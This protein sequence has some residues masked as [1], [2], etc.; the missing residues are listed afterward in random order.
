MNHKIIVGL[1]ALLLVS[2]A[3]VSFVDFSVGTASAATSG[4]FTYQLINGGT[5]VEITGYN[6]SS[7]NVVIPSTI[8][9][10]PVVSIGD[11]AFYGFYKMSTVTIPNSVTYIGNYSFYNC[12][13]SHY[14]D[15]NNI[16]IPD[17]VTRIGDY[18]FAKCGY[19]TTLT[20][21]NSVTS[22]G[23][24]AFW[25]CGDLTSVTIPNSVISIGQ[26]AFRE[27]GIG[28][29]SI[30]SGL[31]N[32]GLYAFLDCRGLYQITVDPNN[33]KYASA[34]GTL[35]D[36][37]MTT[38]IQ[39]PQGNS[40]GNAF[41][42]PDTVTTIGPNAFSGAAIASVTISNKVTSI[43]NSTFYG[44]LGLSTATIGSGVTSIGNNAFSH[45]SF[46]TS[47]SFLGLV[48]PVNV[49]T[50]W[51]DSTP[52]SI[53][54]HAFAASNFPAPGN[55]WNGLTMG[56]TLSATPPGAPTGLVAVGALQHITL[57]WT[58]PSVGVASNYL[59]YRGTA[60]G[61]E[62]STPIATVSSWTTYQDD[63]VIVG[64]PYFY[65]VK[66]NNSYGAS[67]FSNEATATTTTTVTVPSA[68]QNFVATSG[69]NKDT[70]TWSAPAN[71]GGSAITGYKIYRSSG[72]GSA[73]QIGTTG[74]N[75]LT[76]QD[77]QVTAGTTY[78]YYVVAMNSA[79]SGTQSASKSA[80][81]ESS[82]SGGTS[83]NNS[84]YTGIAIV[85]IVLILIGAFW[86]MRS[87]KKSPPKSP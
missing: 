45:C 70:L 26:E 14:T 4:G 46:L 79:G 61:S 62:S 58:A 36:K 57:N 31:T 81:P 23:Y 72:G 66:A 75:T 68:P 11:S 64:T 67:P 20:I 87:R 77:T 22:I 65:K 34:G 15:L 41:I 63:N 30:G 83:N 19:L 78:S 73:S 56:A 71:N 39:C 48:V 3:V 12:G 29:V 33:Q 51:I 55:V 47:I 42:F 24:R 43:G 59:V 86:Y 2:T 60:A 49:G 44:L 69:V 27:S 8:A 82:S 13:N 54:G 6:Q 50:G 5:A 37:A 40:A 1:L 35:Y 18:A 38:V 21:G 16:V 80:T 17:S 53:L 84:L 85:V 32:L 76:Y 10:E 28:T 25:R 7:N 52:S 74:A 9:G